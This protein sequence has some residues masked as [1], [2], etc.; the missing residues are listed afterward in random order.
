MTL[1]K[2][3]ADWDRKVAETIERESAEDEPGVNLEKDSHEDVSMIQND[4]QAF[5][6]NAKFNNDFHAE[7]Y[8][9]F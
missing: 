5:I 6:F 3:M 9:E 1:D 4:M 8:D 2:Y 7:Y